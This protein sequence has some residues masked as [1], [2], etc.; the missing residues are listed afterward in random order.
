MTRSILQEI[1][2]ATAVRSPSGA[3]TSASCS[4][5][6]KHPL[7]LPVPG[8]A[9]PRRRTR[10]WCGGGGA[11]G[12]RGARLHFSRC[13]S[14]RGRRVPRTARCHNAVLLL[15]LQSA[16]EETLARINT[17]S[18]VE[19]Y[20]VIDGTVGERRVRRHRLSEVSKV[21][22]TPQRAP[23]RRLSPPDPTNHPPPAGGGAPTQSPLQCGRRSGAG[24]GRQRARGRSAERGARRADRRRA[25]SVRTGPWRV[26]AIVLDRL[27][28]GCE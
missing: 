3:Y 25:R 4:P 10:E 7:T 6:L 24:G 1:D 8:S 23:W 20:V 26:S 27:P 21:V 13:V 22:A 16:V 19:Y 28:D 14:W 2:R 9:T 17:M 11:Q 5:A 18:G 12:R 15:P